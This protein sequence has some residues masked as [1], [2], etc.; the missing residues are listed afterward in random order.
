MGTGLR[1][2]IANLKEH[3]KLPGP[4]NY[5]SLDD[6]FVKKAAPAYGFG[7]SKRSDMESRKYLQGPGAYQT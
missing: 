1:S 3:S 4:G 2:D 5:H 6:S 7:S